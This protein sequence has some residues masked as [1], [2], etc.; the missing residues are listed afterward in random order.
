MEAKSEKNECSASP[1]AWV[2]VGPRGPDWRTI[3]GAEAE[4][5]RLG[6]EMFTVDGFRR[7]GDEGLY[8][9]RPVYGYAG[10]EVEGEAP[11]AH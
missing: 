3:R 6:R 5:L 7:L 11:D 4:A 9:V 8:A 1:I 10:D 2:V